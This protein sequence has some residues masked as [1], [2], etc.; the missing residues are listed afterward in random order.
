MSADHLFGAT[1]DVEEK[2]KEAFRG[3]PSDI[4]AYCGYKNNL[5]SF[6]R[7]CHLSKVVLGG[8]DTFE[9]AVK[10]E[11]KDLPNTEGLEFLSVKE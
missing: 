2:M 9:L 5:S 11:F 4:K 3:I 7:I 6:E 8:S 1:S 10:T